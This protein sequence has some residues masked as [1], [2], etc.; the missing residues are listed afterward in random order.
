MCVSECVCVCVCV[1]VWLWLWMWECCEICVDMLSVVQLE[2]SA[3]NA[4]C[5]CGYKDQFIGLLDTKRT[6]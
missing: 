3:L 1:C 2:L 6:T 5:V 4:K